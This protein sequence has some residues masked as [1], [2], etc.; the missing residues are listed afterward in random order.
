[1]HTGGGRG[2]GRGKETLSSGLCAERGAGC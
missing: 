2:R 1:M